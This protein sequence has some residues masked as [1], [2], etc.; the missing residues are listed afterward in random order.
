MAI[1]T[2]KDVIKNVLTEAR[3]LNRE[4]DVVYDALRMIKENPDWSITESVLWALR[5][6]EKQKHKL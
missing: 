4:I 5:C 6:W 1:H 2:T 3:R